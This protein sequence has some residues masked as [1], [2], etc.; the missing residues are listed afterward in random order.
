MLQVEGSLRRCGK[1]RTTVGCGRTEV[2]IRTRGGGRELARVVR[3]SIQYSELRQ[4]GNPY[5][6]VVSVRRVDALWGAAQK[7]SGES[8][9]PATEDLVG[10]AS[11]VSQERQVIGRSS[12]K[13]LTNIESGRAP[14]IA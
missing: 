8:E 4:A 12:N 11:L 10:E 13:G 9:P 5:P 14:K 3:L 2:R 7:L 6:S 1:Q